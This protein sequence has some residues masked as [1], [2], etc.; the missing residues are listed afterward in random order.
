MPKK[1]TQRLSKAATR[2][3]GDL[4]VCRGTRGLVARFLQRSKRSL[5]S[6]VEMAGHSSQGHKQVGAPCW[7]RSACR[8]AEKRWQAP[9]CPSPWAQAWIVPY[10]HFQAQSCLARPPLHLSYPGEIA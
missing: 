7:P 8:A 10:R 4:K 5:V 9:C 1:V 6:G 3:L 2:S